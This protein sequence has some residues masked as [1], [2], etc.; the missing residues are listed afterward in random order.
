M[1]SSV[2]LIL[3]TI[4]FI[5]LLNA[6][7]S[8]L[9]TIYTIPTI[10]QGFI[11]ESLNG[12]GFNQSTYSPIFNIASGNPASITDYQ[13][14][15]LGLS[16]QF[17]SA[18]DS[19]FL[20]FKHQRINNNIPQSGGIVYSRNNL[21]F[22]IGYSQ[23]Y[24]SDLT[25]DIPITTV[26]NP[27]GTGEFYKVSIKNSVKCLSPI[28]AYRWDNIISNNDRISIGFQTNLNFLQSKHS[29]LSTTGKLNDEK[30][31]LK[32]GIRYEC[33][34]RFNQEWI[35]GFTFENLIKFSGHY[36]FEPDFIIMGPD[37][38]II[39]NNQSIRA[40]AEF[41]QAETDYPSKLTFGYLFKPSSKVG[42][43][44]DFIYN[45]WKDI[46]QKN[47][48]RVDISGGF[49][50]GA[51]R[52]ISFSLSFLKSEAYSYNGL[53][54]EVDNSFDA[55]FLAT[56][57]I[58]HYSKFDIHLVLANNDWFSEFRRKQTIGKM[59]IGFNL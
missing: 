3:S 58:F 27:D 52:I 29:V 55:V 38:S 40:L 6:Q 12:Y 43:F 33:Q 46:T 15:T 21:S 51:T 23:K 10:H 24:S 57:L 54:D 47:E 14:F 2:I 34:N 28:I 20:N 26:A 25:I 1:K 44:G 37:T 16:Y 32:F 9:A 59:G 42:I 7:S 8:R 53:I 39:G 56:G 5:P 48:N 4:F 11:L 22:G 41:T 49:F 45:Y 50:F 36:E 18:I 35:F 31:N 13:N 19:A 30:I 17:D